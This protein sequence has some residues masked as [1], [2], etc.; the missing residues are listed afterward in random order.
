MI[1]FV[2]VDTQSQRLTVRIDGAPAFSV[3]RHRDDQGDTVYEMSAN[4]FRKAV[5][6]AL[7]ADDRGGAPN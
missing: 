5:E 1:R 4:E 3:G 2:G 7:D 6:D